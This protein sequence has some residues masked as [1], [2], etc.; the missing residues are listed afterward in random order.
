MGEV[1][2]R[3]ALHRA[4]VIAPIKTL[5]TMSLLEPFGSLHR[6]YLGNLIATPLLY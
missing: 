2:I 5:L 4:L 3:I 6:K 1:M